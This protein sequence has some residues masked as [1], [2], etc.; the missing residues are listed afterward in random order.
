VW[1]DI[2]GEDDRWGGHDAVPSNVWT[3]V[4]MV[5]DG[6]KPPA[7]RVRLY[8]N[9]ELDAVGAETSASIT[10]AGS[11]LVVGCLPLFGPAQSFIGSLDDV[12]VWTRALSDAEVRAW[13]QATKM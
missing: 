5:Y 3:Q 13:Y 6:S 4:G 7:E 12:G 8:I 10:Q 2:E 1:S 11:P 9:G